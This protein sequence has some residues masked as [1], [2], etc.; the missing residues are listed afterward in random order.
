M[1]LLASLPAA[2]RATLVEAAK[3]AAPAFRAGLLR[4][5]VPGVG[6]S[7]ARFDMVF[8]WFGSRYSPCDGSGIFDMHGHVSENI[9][10]PLRA[11]PAALCQ[12]Q[13]YRLLQVGWCLGAFL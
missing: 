12:C 9:T 3:L 1:A 13:V 2:I 6:I 8:G 5:P 11:S 10:P 7:W 4:S